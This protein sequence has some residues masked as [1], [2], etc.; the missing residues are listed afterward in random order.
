MVSKTTGK[1]EFTLLTGK[2][3]LFEEFQVAE[4]NDSYIVSDLPTPPSSKIQNKFRTTKSLCKTSISIL[5]EENAE[6]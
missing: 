4:D 2:Y 6:C 5:L 1:D 3:L